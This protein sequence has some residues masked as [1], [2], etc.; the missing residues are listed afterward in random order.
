[1]L[2][3]GLSCVAIAMPYRYDVSAVYSRPEIDDA[4]HK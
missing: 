4:A 1:M 3:T 2:S